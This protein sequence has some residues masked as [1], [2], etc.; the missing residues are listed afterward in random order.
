MLRHQILRIFVAHLSLVIYEV[1][2]FGPMWELDLSQG[3]F[4]LLVRQVRKSTRA[5]VGYLRV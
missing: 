4:G 3:W 2:S 5:L 1:S